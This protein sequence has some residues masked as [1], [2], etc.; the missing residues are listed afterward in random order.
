MKVLWLVLLS[1]W[2]VSFAAN[3]QP[4]EPGGGRARVT[5]VAVPTHPHDPLP[6]KYTCCIR[7]HGENSNDDDDDHRHGRSCRMMF[8]DDQCP[9]HWLTVTNHKVC[10]AK[11][12]KYNP[13]LPIYGQVNL[14]LPGYKLKPCSL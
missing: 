2:A 4:L 11:V 8:A 1:F 3:G 6:P 12:P 9:K 14:G 13:R 10:L 7:T 5:P